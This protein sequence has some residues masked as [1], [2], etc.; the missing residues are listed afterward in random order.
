MTRRSACATL[1]RSDLPCRRNSA[2]DLE[3]EPQPGAERPAPAGGCPEPAA[4]WAGLPVQHPPAARA[5]RQAAGASLVAF[6]PLLVPACRLGRSVPSISSGSDLRPWRWSS[7][8]EQGAS[9]FVLGVVGNLSSGCLSS[10]PAKLLPPVLQGELEIIT[11]RAPWPPA[12]KRAFAP[13]PSPIPVARCGGG[14]L[15]AGSSGA[16]G[17]SDL[18]G[19]ACSTVPLPTPP[20]PSPAD[21][22]CRRPFRQ[23]QPPSRGSPSPCAPAAPFPGAAFAC[24]AASTSPSGD[25]G[26]GR[27]PRA[28]GVHAVALIGGYDA[29]RPRA[30]AKGELGVPAPTHEF[31]V[32][33]SFHPPGGCARRIVVSPLRYTPARR[34]PRAGIRRAIR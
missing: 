20:W 1:D 30:I 12:R 10:A 16:Q 28:P 5:C 27:E 19:G 13:E 2:G 15:E 9:G 29:P 22:L 31:Q 4:A 21:A 11:R 6:C 17:R 33:C 32:P 34:G 14:H 7:C 26:R 3:A 24:C 18:A 23:A 25:R 8:A